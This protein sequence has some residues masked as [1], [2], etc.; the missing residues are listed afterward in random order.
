MRSHGWSPKTVI[1]VAK[2]QNNS[3]RNGKRGVG[4]GEK[5][6]ERGNTRISVDLAYLGTNHCE[7]LEE[8]AIRDRST[9]RSLKVFAVN[10]FFIFQSSRS[11][12]CLAARS[13]RDLAA[14]HPKARLRSYNDFGVLLCSLTV[15]SC[16][17]LEFKHTILM[18]I[19]EVNFSTEVAKEKG[20][21]VGV[22]WDEGRMFEV[23]TTTKIDICLS[24]YSYKEPSAKTDSCI[25]ESLSSSTPPNLG[26]GLITTGIKV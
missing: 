10:D 21:T 17:A 26:L 7:I 6:A 22:M 12:D 18:C 23:L 11:Q 9:T 1:K 15:S 19:L 2:K 4:G 14:E 13:L 24:N 16:L 3:K 5:S 25:P 8:L 20:F